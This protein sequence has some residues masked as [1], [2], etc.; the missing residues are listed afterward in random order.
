M[1]KE[2][3]MLSLEKRRLW[4]DR[5]ALFKYLKRCHS[6]EGQDL[7][8]IIPECGAFDNMFNLQEARF[9]LNIR[10]YVLIVRAV[11]QWNQLPQEVGSSLAVETFKRNLDSHL[12]DIFPYH[13]HCW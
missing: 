12:T 10:K 3:D 8:S 9:Q 7:F 2:L 4:G 5:I 11:W 1:K 13:C 6:E